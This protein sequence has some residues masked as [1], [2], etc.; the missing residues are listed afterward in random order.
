[1]FWKK[2]DI[3]SGKIKNL[4]SLSKLKSYLGKKVYAK[5]GDF[6]GYV[7]D[8][9]FKGNIIQGIFVKGKRN[10]FIGKEFFEH[11]SEEAFVLSIDPVVCLIGKQVFDSAGKRIGKVIDIKRKSNA[12]TYSELIIKKV[13]YRRAF[14]IP[15]EDVSVAKQNIIL[16]HAL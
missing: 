5:K 10:I 4:D 3:V 14:S 15:K 12:N 2:T 6:I 16:K 8:V 13:F 1:M 11:E 7:R 9:M